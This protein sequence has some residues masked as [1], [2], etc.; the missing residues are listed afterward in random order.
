M[1]GPPFSSS[2]QVGWTAGGGIEYAFLPNLT[3]KVEY[4]FVD[5]Q[6]QTCGVGNCGG[7]TFA[8]PVN[9]S[10]SLNENIIRAGINYKFG[11]GGW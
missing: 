10:V 6:D 3:A 8:N 1:A 7:G 9:T 2:T 4:L 5:L 11:Y